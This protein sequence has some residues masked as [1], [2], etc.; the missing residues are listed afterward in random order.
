[1][2]KKVY[3]TCAKNAATHPEAPDMPASRHSSAEVAT[4]RCLK[5]IQQK[6][7]EVANFSLKEKVA[8]LQA[9]N[10]ELETLAIALQAPVVIPLNGRCGHFTLI[11]ASATA[12]NL[13][14]TSTSKTPVSLL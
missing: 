2:P 5:A 14:T 13:A 6:E 8:I 4:E 1:M 11:N 9:R 12:V 7:N 10:K 3:G